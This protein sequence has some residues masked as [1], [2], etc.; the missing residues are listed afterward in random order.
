MKGATVTDPRLK[1]HE[2][3]VIP[4]A[5][6]DADV[7]VLGS[8]SYTNRYLAIASLSGQE[9]LIRGALLSDDTLYFASAIE[10]LGHVRTEID[11]EDASIR[12]IP[13]GQPMRAPA[14][15]VFMG[16]AYTPDELGEIEVDEGVADREQQQ[17][18][19]LAGAQTAAAAEK[20]FR[21]WSNEG[22]VSP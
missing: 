20:M 2:L 16:A 22:L 9:T 18:D 11:H 21:S 4:L 8:K 17:L 1:A 12:V 19:A 13:T 6:I 7:S 14:D 5:G 15:D 3:T 10:A